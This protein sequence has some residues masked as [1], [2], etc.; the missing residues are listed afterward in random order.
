M[1][2]KAVHVEFRTRR[3][4]SRWVWGGVAAL[5][6]VAVGMA[7][8]AG[9]FH[10]ERRA[11]NDELLELRRSQQVVP[12]VPG[13]PAYAGSAHELVSEASSPWPSMLV[14]LETASMVGVTPI[15]IDVDPA[16]E[17]V[18]V[19][20]EFA[21]YAVLLKYVEELNAGAK[22]AMWSLVRAQADAASQQTQK[23]STALLRAKLRT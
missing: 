10:R 8:G 23:H 12:R 15:S 5:A 2:M 11:L 7:V 18:L 1:D 22:T 6:L 4:P 3:L 20:V 16:G 14:A 21:D 17:Q 9:I 13:A 19:E